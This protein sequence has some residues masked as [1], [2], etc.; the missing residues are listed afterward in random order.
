MVFRKALFRFS[1]FDE[2]LDRIKC[3][4]EEMAPYVEKI[5]RS[6]KPRLMFFFQL[7]KN[8]LSLIQDS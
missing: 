6:S 8:S 1:Y 2:G 4:G 3:A 5:S 7:K